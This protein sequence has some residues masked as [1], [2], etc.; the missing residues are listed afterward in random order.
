VALEGPGD[1]AQGGQFAGVRPH[2]DV[3][4]TIE[5]EADYAPMVTGKP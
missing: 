1:E 3:L 2:D 5:R 4:T